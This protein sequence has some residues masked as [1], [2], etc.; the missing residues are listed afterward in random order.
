MV[1]PTAG[2]SARWCISEFTRDNGPLRVIPGSH[3]VGEPPLDTEHGY[4][5][6]WAR[7][8]TR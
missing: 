1:T 4:A 2:L 6:G 5:I 7:I 3:L 8:P